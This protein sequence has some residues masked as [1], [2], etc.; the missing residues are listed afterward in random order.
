MPAKFDVYEHGRW[1]KSPFAK[2]YGSGGGKA[3]EHWPEAMGID[4][5]AAPEMAQAIPPAYTEFVG[6]Y[7]MAAV[8]Q[9]N[10]VRR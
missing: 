3:V 1:Y 9:K 6:G 5:M 7:L 8:Q 2:V 10:P 4:W